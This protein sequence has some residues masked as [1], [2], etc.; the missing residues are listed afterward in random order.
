MM[1]KY[2]AALGSVLLVGLAA[3]AASS[4]DPSTGS[5]DIISTSQ[6]AFSTNCAIDVTVDGDAYHGTL[7]GP[8]HIGKNGQ[9]SSDKGKLAINVATSDGA[10]KF[11]NTFTAKSGTITDAENEVFEFVM[12]DVKYGYDLTIKYDGK[13]KTANVE[14]PSAVPFFKHKNLTFNSSCKFQ[15]A[16]G[17][18]TTNVTPGPAATH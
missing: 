1:N 15:D 17:N 14:Y 5:D 9:L 3:C 13:S 4:G 11:N 12:E 2:I 10:K 18:D 16:E 7:G 8:F 6:A